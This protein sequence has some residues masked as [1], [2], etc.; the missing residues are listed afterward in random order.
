MLWQLSH[1]MDDELSAV[2]FDHQNARIVAIGTRAKPG[3]KKPMTNAEL[4][5]SDSEKWAQE[6]GEVKADVYEARTGHPVSHSILKYFLPT[7]IAFDKSGSEALVG[8]G[9]SSA[10]LLTVPSLQLVQ[11]F[12]PRSKSSRVFKKNGTG[13]PMSCN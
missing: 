7:T 13:S 3:P 11:E 10:R 2:A 5:D 9:E 1:D 12:R 8:D 4:I 6:S